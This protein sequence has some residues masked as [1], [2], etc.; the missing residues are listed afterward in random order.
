MKFFALGALSMLLL[1]GAMG[2]V[3]YAANARLET[4][5]AADVALRAARARG[6]QTAQPAAPA[7]QIAAASAQ[8]M[9]LR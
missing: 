2:G 8:V 6:V 3:I 7:D 4:E 5:Y 1:A 9:R